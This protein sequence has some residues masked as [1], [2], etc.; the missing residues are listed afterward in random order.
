M[1]GP[2]NYASTLKP[3]AVET[4]LDLL[5][6]RPAG[7]AL[8]RLLLPTRITPNQVTLASIATGLVGAALSASSRRGVRMAGALLG[9]VYGVLDCADGQLARARGE[10]SRVGRILDGAGDYVVGVATGLAVATTLGRRHGPSGR[11]LAL[12]GVASIVVQGTLFDH[13]KN[14][15]LSRTG[16]AYREGDDL[17]ETLA[18]LERLR[19][20]PGSLGERF[21]LRGYA[22]FLSFQARL[23]GAREAVGRPPLEGEAAA[24]LA[25]LARA[26]AWLGPST[27]VASLALFVVADRLAL[28]AWLRLVPANVLAAWLLWSFR[29]AERGTHGDAKGAAGALRTFS[30]PTPRERATWGAVAATAIPGGAGLPAAGE[31]TV[32]RVLAALVAAPPL[33]SAA[34]RGALGLLDAHAR[35]KHRRGF[36]ALSPSERAAIL[37]G[38]HRGGAL[39]RGLLRALLVPLKAAHFDDP[40]LHASLGCVY[41]RE[42]PRVSAHPHHVEARIHRGEALE[43]DVALACDVV[44]VGTGAGGAVVGKELAEAGAAVVF[45]EEGDYFDRR[46]FSGRPLP[47]Q[48]DLYRRSGA[49]FAIGNTFIPIPMGRTVGGSTTVNSGTCFR[50]PDRVLTHWRDGLGLRDFDPAT[51][52]RHYERVERLLGVAPARTELLGGNARVIA[53]GCEAIGLRSHGPLRRNA[54][55][56]D[57]QGVCCFGCPTDAKRSTNVSYVPMAL[58]AGAALFAGCSVSSVL[59]EGGRAIGVVARSRSGRRLTVRSKIVV[60]AGGAVMTPG[61]LAKQRLG[62]ASGELGRNLSIHPAA[63]LLA[64]FDERIAGWDGIPQGYAIEDLV[65]EGILFE[66][67]TLPLE[68]TLGLAP[69]WGA[70]L[71]RLAERFDRLASFGFMIED[72]S[73]GRVRFVRGEPML[74]YRLGRADVERV[75]RGVEVLARVFFAAGATR[76]YTPVA[77]FET[78]AGEGALRGLAAAT[79]RARDLDLSAYHPLGTARMGVDRRRSVVDPDHQVHDVPGLYVVDGSVVPTSLGVNPQVTIMAMATRAAEQIAARL[80]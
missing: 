54:P 38:W 64:E 62:G 32:T 33:L 20:E 39:P 61:L 70:D 76:V 50:A 16:A 1:S 31:E 35:C 77:G 80:G 4:P 25:R 34:L 48:R 12:A 10:S 59:L 9:V 23:G 67:A 41:E 46:H 65:G 74:T 51:F 21:L 56:C 22:V 63:G 58:R 19:A 44:V 3:A 5:F 53:R 75:R 11:A 57:G 72:T 49:T 14:R 2:A 18:E 36:I 17:S 27:H 71:V 66:G 60:V 68:M 26:W 37:D 28:Y 8:V 73:R 47:M 30:L 45:I 13:A 6:F 69:H 40:A 43:D 24:R 7:F 15:Y 42:R 78:L 52:A 79:L 55:D 29:D